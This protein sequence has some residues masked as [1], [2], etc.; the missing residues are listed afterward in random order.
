ML[1]DMAEIVALGFG[2]A[3]LQFVTV[4]GKLIQRI[5][6]FSCTAE[7]LP[8]ALRCI[9]L[10]LP[11]LLETCQN[12]DTGNETESVTA[13][14][15]GCLREVEGLYSL[16]NK[17]LPGPEDTKLSRA[18]KAIKS[19]RCEDKL[20][21]A[22]KKIEQF[23]TD[24]I[25]HCCQ[26]SAGAQ[27]T[28]SST[29][30]VTHSLPPTPTMPSITR[31]KL[32]QEIDR[33]FEEHKREDSGHNIVVL[34]GMGGQG[35]S[36]LAYD[37]GGRQMSKEDN[38]KLVV[39]LDART[40][41][42][43][44]RN[45]EDIADR[46][47]SRNRRLTDTESRIKFVKDILAERE[48]LLILDNY[49]QPQHFVDIC[50]FIPPGHG[51]V[52][53]TSR[54]TDTGTLGKTIKLS[55]MDEGEGLELLR[56]RTDQSLDDTTHRVEAV[57]ILQILGHLPL[58][59]DQA[60]AYI[61]QQMLPLR[62]FVKLY[63][64]QKATVLNQRYIYWDYKKRLDDEEGEATPLGV[65]T[66]FELSIQQVSGTRTTQAMVEH[67][68][69]IAAF[70]GYVEVSENLFR[71]YALRARPTPG[72]LECFIT[73][74]E[75]DTFA[76]RGVVLELLRLSLAQGRISSTGDF[77]LSLHPMIKDWL[78][79]R[80][81]QAE[82]CAYVMETRDILANFISMDVQ[83]R[84]LEEARGLLEHLDACMNSQKKNQIV[85]SC[86][87]TGH[88]RSHAITFSTFYMSH[89][90]YREAEEGFQAVLDHDI[91]IYGKNHAYTLQAV[92]RLADAFVNGGKYHE[93]HNL[94]STTIGENNHN[95]DIEKLHLLSGL[96]AVFAKLDRPADAETY[97]ETALH[98]HVI[99]KENGVSHEVYQT[100]ERLAE[101]KR[102]LGK[103]CE[104]E[105]LY[106]AARSGYEEQCTYH[107]DTT[108]D[109][110]RTVGGLADLHRTHGRYKEAESAYREAWQGYK[111]LLGPDHPST[112][113]MLT[114]LGIACRN[115]EKY[116]EAET[117]LEESVKAFQKNLGSDH[118]DTLRAL[119]NLSICIDR[120]GHYKAAE[121]NYGRVLL[122]RERKLGLHHPYTLRTVERL[123]HMLWM[124][125]HHD[126]A[127]KFARGILTRMG[128][129][130]TAHQP[131]YNNLRAFP[132]L[133]K[134]YDDAWK[135]C[136]SKLSHD[137]VDTLETREC[138][139]LVY[140]ES[141]EHNEAK[142]L[143]DQARGAQCE[144]DQVC[145]LENR[146]KRPERL[147]SVSQG[148][149]TALQ[150]EQKGLNRLDETFRRLDQGNDG[151]WH[152]R[153]D[154]FW[155]FRRYTL[156]V[157]KPRTVVLLLVL[158]LLFWLIR[159]RHLAKNLP[160]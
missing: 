153:V 129:Q 39:W 119:M 74:S 151:N 156:V 77:C 116:T 106:L 34:L 71:E 2:A 158:C 29:Q 13:I 41:K 22:L 44:T 93:A 108:R 133:I 123:A 103:H 55:G 64:S 135:R 105:G 94:L 140:I 16:I 121:V 47:S 96:A 59:V 120:Q 89:G 36:R 114:N 54:H 126:R 95:A 154:Q 124:Q 118:P 144:K 30:I 33:S 155:P 72:W 132:A 139:R 26:T 110:L 35:K 52:L 159:C 117:Y 104:A 69:T 40:K 125:G 127:E 115:Q 48:W 99:R 9:H 86:L 145:G 17:I 4:A 19:I 160:P 6:E 18:Y 152:V 91:Q 12:L 32:L 102:Y 107:Q 53:I 141:G 122:E 148:L 70:L 147:L 137:H 128:M 142:R 50:T 65:L 5:D 28:V 56:R 82:R 143:T 42:T 92:K 63:D 98:G 100:Y 113:F 136:K 81:T 45:L 66:T 75:W 87:G 101:V 111:R 37:Y 62:Q 31:H 58:A 150:E 97:Y 27:V 131:G 149:K 73:D 25:L 23:K 88:L 130:P 14:L 43:L 61:R 1:N 134:L 10:Q 57:K 84:S 68:L 109:I 38:P 67:L 46:W 79:L 78:Q 60:G 112:T 21:L 76:Y 11:F 51:S 83:D 20:E 80:I 138:L 24:L 49:D 146:H 7:E 15:N 90:R 3:I 157:A 8:K 85:S